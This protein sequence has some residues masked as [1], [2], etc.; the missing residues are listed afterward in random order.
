MST[1]NRDII[2]RRIEIHGSELL[3]FFFL[4]PLFFLSFFFFPLRASSRCLEAMDVVCS[5][6]EFFCAHCPRPDRCERDLTEPRLAFQSH[7]AFLKIIH[8]GY[9]ERFPY[10]NRKKAWRLGHLRWRALSAAP[11]IS[12]PFVEGNND[13]FVMRTN[14]PNCEIVR[15]AGS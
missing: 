6:K 10:F 3:I 5:D 9:L 11:L 1:L 4:L 7:Y 12:P 2:S 14:L 13:N 15:G 8:A